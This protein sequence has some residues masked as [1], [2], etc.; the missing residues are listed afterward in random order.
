MERLNPGRQSLARHR[1]MTPARPIARFWATRLQTPNPAKARLTPTRPPAIVAVSE[2]T[3][4]LLN[5]SSRW[6]IAICELLRALSMKLIDS[7]LKTGARRSSETLVQE[8][9]DKGRENRGQ[10]HQTEIFWTQEARQ[11]YKGDEPDSR[12]APLLDDGP[13]NSFS[14]FF[15]QAHLL[16]ITPLGFFLLSIENCSSPYPE[17]SGTHP[18]F[19]FRTLVP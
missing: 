17:I 7:H 14:C 19:P 9:I 2:R 3:A 18:P 15:S 4:R 5:A 6:R 11:G 10:G 1:T 12:P 16:Q 13:N 8:N